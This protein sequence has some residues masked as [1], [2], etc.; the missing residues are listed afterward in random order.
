M[1]QMKSPFKV[2]FAVCCLMVV[3]GLLPLP[4]TYYMLLRLIICGCAIYAAVLIK[5]INQTFQWVA[6]GLALLYN[7][8]IPVFLY[9]KP[10]WVIINLATL[11]FFWTVKVAV[12]NRS[13]STVHP[14]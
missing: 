8:V 7:P 12:K 1:G 3:I 10:L 6:V 14:D 13:A 5:P 4:Y 9:S 2:P 11:W